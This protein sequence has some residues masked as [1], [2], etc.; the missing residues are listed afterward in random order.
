MCNLRALLKKNTGF[1]WLPQ[2]SIDFKAIVQELYS[3]KLLK[4][5]DSTKK[6]YL[7]VDTSQKAIGMALMQFVQ[8][9]HGSEAIDGQHEG[10]VEASVNDC[11][12]P[13]IPTDLLPVAYSSKTLTDAE[14][15]YAN[16]DH[17]LLGVVARM[18][19]FHTF[20][21][22]W[23]IIVLSDHKPLT[24]IVRKDLVN[25][26]PRL[27]QLLLRLQKYNFEILYEPGKS[28]I[29]ADQLSHNIHPEA[30]I[31]PTIPDLNLD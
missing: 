15:R 19:K 13:N 29:F 7:E 16:I 2:H 28:M 8:N 27:Q 24:S 21:Y 4:Y 5:Y 12:K 6:L 17:E 14:G 1:L 11:G 9:E 23:S 30:S 18:E 10:R 20:C 31:M 3:P 26:P 22:G 25:A